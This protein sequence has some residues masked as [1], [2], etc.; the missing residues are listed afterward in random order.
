MSTLELHP[1]C[2]LFPRLDGTE[3]EALKADI[4]INGQHQPITVYEG[5]ILD[6]GNRYRACIEAGIEPA[7]EEF[8]GNDPASFVLSANMHRRH[9]AQGQMAAIVAGA[10]DWSRAQRA[11]GDRRSDHSATLHNDSAADRA[12]KSGASLRTQQ[13]ADKVTKADPEL[14]KR[15]RMGEISLPKALDELAPKQAAARTTPPAVSPIT[16]HA[17]APAPSNLVRQVLEQQAGVPPAEL[18]ESHAAEEEVGAAAD[19]GHQ[20]LLNDYNA[21]KL[22]R[23]ALQAKVAEL[24]AHIALLCRDDLAAQVDGLV[25]RAEGAEYKF[26]QLCGRNR[27]LQGKVR[28]TQ[29]ANES[30]ISLLAKIR[31]ASGVESNAEILPALTTRRAA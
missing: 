18:D 26:E 9:L 14:A 3:F 8:A 21:V 12:A 28:D 30:L 25:K 31:K 7:L 15:V 20:E 29:L 1:L 2:T 10:Q 4:V 19:D 27:D 17:A 6:G 13:M 5:Q 11:G 24:E 16:A 22:D 23:D